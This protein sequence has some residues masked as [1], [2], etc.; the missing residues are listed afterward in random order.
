[1][2]IEVSD[3][4]VL[5]RVRGSG[6]G[7]EV[8]GKSEKTENTEPS[9]HL[10]V[11]DEKSSALAKGLPRKFVLSVGVQAIDQSIKARQNR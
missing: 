7:S 10:L 9:Q 8:E 1:L 4:E 2:R 11:G 5:L 3:C 6:N